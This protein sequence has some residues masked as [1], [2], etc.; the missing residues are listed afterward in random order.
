MG[1]SSGR[2]Q[3]LQ[4]VRTEG[5][6][7]P[8]VTEDILQALQETTSEVKKRP[9]ARS[10]MQKRS[11]A[12]KSTPVTKKKPAVLKRRL[13]LELRRRYS[14]KKYLIATITTIKI[15]TITIT[16]NVTITVPLQAPLPPP[17]A[18][19][20]AL[21]DGTVTEPPTP[22]T[23]VASIPAPE[24]PSETLCWPGEKLAAETPKTVEEIMA[25][26]TELLNELVGNSLLI[27]FKNQLDEAIVSV[28]SVHGV[29]KLNYR[30]VRHLARVCEL[31]DKVGKL[32]EQ[33]SS[34]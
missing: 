9:A 22:A 2:L 19:P 32:I 15:P 28:K 24:T 27:G 29:P 23:D 12:N 14:T 30:C 33:S 16:V 4:K 34:F 20:A 25:K 17:A 13:A 3:L 1:P 18:E 26:A 8:N 5:I 21:M 6:D 31:T 10:T 7:I 11:A